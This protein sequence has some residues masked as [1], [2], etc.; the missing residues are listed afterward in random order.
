MGDS[1]EELT[2]KGSCALHKAWHIAYTRSRSEQQVAVLLQ[3]SGISHFLPLTRE[4]RQ[5]S[6]RKKW[7]TRP[8][9][10]SYIFVKINRKEYA[11]VLS[12]PGCVGY[13]KLANKAVTISETRME[14]I[15]RAV[16]SNRVVDV[17]P[18]VPAVGE[19]ISMPD[20]PLKGIKGTVVRTD[21]KHYLLLAV[22]ELGKYLKINI[23]PEEL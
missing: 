4:L 8:L 9:F 21:G 16:E 17:L 13:V 3:R 6:D 23:Q 11:D 15:R 19:V 2:G 18:F 5:W 22:E 20:G 14:E 12:I 1:T 10:P 7:V